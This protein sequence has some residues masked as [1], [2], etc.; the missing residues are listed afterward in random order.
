MV[1]AFLPL[2]PMA[3][4]GFGDSSTALLPERLPPPD[5][6]ERWT[7]LQALRRTAPPLEP[8]ISSLERGAPE[9]LPDLLAALVGH[10]D[11]PS[12][13]RLLRWWQ[14][15]PEADPLLPERIVR[16][17]H[18]DLAT[19][20]RVAV[21]ASGFNERG[22]ILLPL[23]GH[24]RQSADFTLL[25][26]TVLAPLP[27]RTRRAALEG[28]LLGLA[29]W[30]PEALRSTLAQLATD[31]DPALAA[32]AVDG[33][34]RLS[35]ARRELLALREQPLA[36]SVAHRLERRLRERAP[37]PLLLLV[38]GRADGLIPAEL[39][40]LA[41]DLERQ[42]GAPVRLLALTAT[43][44][45]RREPSF[46]SG[47]RSQDSGP[48]GLPESIWPRGEHPLGLVPLLLLPGAHVRH[49]LPALAAALARQGP[50]RRWPFLGAWPH[51][52]RCLAME[53][54]HLA[55]ATAHQTIGSQAEAEVP[56]PL[57]LHHPLEGT[58]GGRYLQQLARHCGVECRAA[59]WSSAP[60]PLADRERRRPV[61]PLTLAANR[62]T[63]SLE[64]WLGKEASRPLL[65]RPA[66]SRQL[67][68]L[69]TAL[70]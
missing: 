5:S 17:R 23:L 59:A 27:L 4:D 32:A 38:H 10:L 40:E 7:F 45:A 35:G 1:K 33:L 19:W 25:S 65:Q 68:A 43:E 18:P 61:L 63:E 15:H 62:L 20:L 36:A 2:S 52:Q 26:Q 34:A 9:P 3:T 14:A 11:P 16:R 47:D 44:I 53:A 57:L 42:R 30:P 41:S 6:P 66:I 55:L 21:R 31:L 67:L 69:L 54:H 28:L 46:K 64:P 49:D 56:L 70:P 13:L 48:C 12:V 24:Q 60:P 37:A 50:L 39:Q 22:I 29:A 8:W 51:W 58:L